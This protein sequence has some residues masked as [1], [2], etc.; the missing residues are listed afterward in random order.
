ML[1]YLTGDD[2]LEPSQK[3]RTLFHILS[4]GNLPEEFKPPTMS[5]NN[6]NINNNNNNNTSINPAS[7]HSTPDTQPLKGTLEKKSANVDKHQKSKPFSPHKDDRDIKK[8]NHS[9]KTGNDR[10]A[11][12]HSPS[13]ARAMTSLAAPVAS[14]IAPI[15]SSMY[16]AP[17]L[18]PFPYGIP[19]GY[20]YPGGMY[21][22]FPFP[23]PT[24]IYKSLAA[25][26]ALAITTG[27]TN[28]SSFSTPSANYTSHT[29]SSSRHSPVTS[30]SRK[31]TRP[32]VSKSLKKETSSKGRSPLPSTG[33]S[34]H[35][36]P[37]NVS[38]GHYMSMYPPFG[39]PDMT[40]M[41]S[42]SK[43]ATPNGHLTKPSKTS[44]TPSATPSETNR[45]SKSSTRP[46]KSHEHSGVLDLS[47]RK[48][49]PI[50]SR[51]SHY[52]P[53]KRPCYEPS[54]HNRT[55]LVLDLSKTSAR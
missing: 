1:V 2:K 23:D 18:F 50:P 27:T 20:L 25:S 38:A 41:P 34:V 54:F 45:T 12:N 4:S 17:P 13:V 35:P 43:V 29:S 26:H 39:L 36:L 3:C 31:D 21:G 7:T 30:S 11:T 37:A 48:R 22:G 6:N 16:L 8:D 14:P 28:N 49:S 15:P 19:P 44:A 46:R 42:P 53:S 55:G 24:A 9:S 5:N 32:S 10:K 33:S 40:Y 47:V 52:S 51:D